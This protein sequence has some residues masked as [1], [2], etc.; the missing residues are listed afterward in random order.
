MLSKASYQKYFDFMLRFEGDVHSFNR[1]KE[2]D[3]KP[4]V[5]E[6]N[7]FESS[8]ERDLYSLLQEFKV[9]F[10]YAICNSNKFLG[11]KDE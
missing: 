1:I 7:Q 3:G 8:I 5:Y 10:R 9:T 2:K 4:V 6:E 11:I